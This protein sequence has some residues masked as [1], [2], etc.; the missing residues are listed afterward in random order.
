[1]KK[2]LF[3][4]IILLPYI[5]FSQTKIEITPNLVMP[6]IDIR[7]IEFPQKIINFDYNMALN[8]TMASPWN[9]PIAKAKN[10]DLY[11]ILIVKPIENLEKILIAKPK[12]E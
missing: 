9:M 4:T 6:K 3:L 5:V 10:P 12:N 1:M 2:L 11:K 8:R 7:K